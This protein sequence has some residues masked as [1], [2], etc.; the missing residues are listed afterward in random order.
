MTENTLFM[1]FM[2]T[3]E[4]IITYTLGERDLRPAQAK[5]RALHRDEDDFS[6]LK[7][8]IKMTSRLFRLFRFKEIN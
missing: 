6:D 7:K 5:C 4:K 2:V 3:V 8:S 1:A